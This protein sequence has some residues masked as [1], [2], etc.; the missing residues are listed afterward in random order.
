MEPSNLVHGGKKAY[1]SVDYYKALLQNK[2]YKVE[3]ITRENSTYVGYTNNEGI[4]M[5]SIYINDNQT[6]VQVGNEAFWDDNND[7]VIDRSIEKRGQYQVHY[8]ASIFNESLQVGLMT[9]LFRT[10]D[11]VN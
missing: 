7:G 9:D 8:E 2:G 10:Q 1:A 11:M 4:H 5:G 3:T 6:S